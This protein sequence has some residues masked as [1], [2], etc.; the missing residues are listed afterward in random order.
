MPRANIGSSA[1]NRALVYKLRLLTHQDIVGE[2]VILPD[3]LR[4]D[5]RRNPSEPLEIASKLPPDD[6]LQ[7]A[8]PP[9]PL[10]RVVRW[11]SNLI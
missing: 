9:P 10:P 11:L 6:F 1:I 7:P 5:G 2:V 3:L 4:G 8:S